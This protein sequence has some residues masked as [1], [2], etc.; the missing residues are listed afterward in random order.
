MRNRDP[1]L[2]VLKDVLPQTGLVLEIASGS[3]EHAA[4]IGP[5]FPALVW[6][7]SAPQPDSRQSIT[8]W[9][10]WLSQSGGNVDN[11]PPPLELD[12]HDDPWPVVAADAVICINMVHISPW[13]T[14]QAL[15]SGAARILPAGG[16]LYLY[17]P[18][19]VDGR[20]TADSNQSFDLDLRR[21]N[22]EWGIRDLAKVKEEAA[23]HGLVFDDAIVMPA[24]NFSVI[25]RNS[26][27]SGLTD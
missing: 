18:Y 26:R 25:F 19:L 27:P 4:Y 1:I 13:V 21:R 17:G 16:P 23:C 3:G 6:Q 5:Q 7:S 10:D 12:V 11:L 24:N 15:L 22:P 9:I 2:A 20:H 14:T 8:G